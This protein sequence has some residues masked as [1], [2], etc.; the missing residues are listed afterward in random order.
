MTRAMLD[1]TSAEPPR[2]SA[3]TDMRTA[4]IEALRASGLVQVDFDDE[5]SAPCLHN[6][7]ETR[8]VACG[9]AL[10]VP[11]V[12]LDEA[13]VCSLCRRYERNR[14]RINAY[15]SDSAALSRLLRRDGRSRGGGFDCMLLYSGGK[16]STYAL[17][18]LVELGLSVTTFTLD[19]GF[20]S[21]RALE[22]IQRV[23]TSLGI[24]HTTLRPAGIGETLKDSLQRLSTP[25]VG[26]FRSLLDHALARA[27]AEGVGFVVTGLSRGQIMQE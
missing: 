9:I 14:E 3:A 2:L 21:G 8:C 10:R 23:T 22:N 26:C 17:Y 4:V 13:Q 19:N 12:S 7:G 16:D 18:K 6:D 1:T 24:A 25:C 20:I 15:F 27:D 5:Q 11:G